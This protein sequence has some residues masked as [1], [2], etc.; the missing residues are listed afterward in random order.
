MKSRFFK[1][2]ICVFLGLMMLLSILPTASAAEEQRYYFTTA[3]SVNNC[4]TDGGYYVTG[5]TLEKGASGENS[6]KMSGSSRCLWAVTNAILETMPY[7]Y[8]KTDGGM[9][10]FT[11]S[12]YWDVEPE[13]DLPIEE[14][15]HCINL[16][17]LVEEYDTI[18]W[19][20][21]VPYVWVE[22]VEGTSEFEYFYLSNMDEEG[23]V[24]E[25]P[26]QP[27]APATSPA[28]E[29][30]WQLKA[31]T[32]DNVDDQ[33]YGWLMDVDNIKITLDGDDTDGKDGFTME[34]AEGSEATAFNIAWVVPYEIVE[35]Y[36][37]LAVEIG[38]EGRLDQGPRVSIYAYWE[39]V[40]G[41]GAF[42][43]VIPS[44]I[45]ATSLNGTTRFPLKYAVDNVKEELHGE[46]GIAIIIAVGINERADGTTLDP[47][48]V[49]NA[50]LY[51]VKEGW[52]NYSLDDDAAGGGNGA[53]GGIGIIVG[54]LVGSV[55]IAAIVVVV[56][57]FAFKKKRS[58]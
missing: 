2:G 53:S 22:G 16:L 47:L 14:G 6:I 50:Y 7:L 34:R 1:K 33:G 28:M 41:S 49:E 37:Y 46:D 20:Y 3:Q 4:A 57:V 58:N 54:I 42:F 52:E 56:M 13:I 24:Y 18:G 45:G 51:N 10:K 30:R 25:K 19:T 12:H 8:Y 35:Q 21:I 43:D 44:E 31:D 40:V 29:E 15:E 26:V 23:N 11:V 27:L 38:N 36:P 32:Q 55:V 5:L 48:L 39:H 9:N 17:E